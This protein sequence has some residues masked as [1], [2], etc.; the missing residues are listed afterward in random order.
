MTDAEEFIYSTYHEIK[1]LGISN[2]SRVSLVRSS[3]NQ[4]LYIRRIIPGNH[5]AV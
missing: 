4:N 3:L 5:E 2:T 1:E